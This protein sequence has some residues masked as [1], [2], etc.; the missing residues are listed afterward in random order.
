VNLARVAPM[1]LVLGVIG[2]APGVSAQW[3]N[4]VPSGTPLTPDGRPDLSAPA[5]RTAEGTPDLTGVWTHELTPLDEMRRLFGPAIDEAS[6][7]ELPGM[8]IGTV[9]KYGI[10]VLAELPPGQVE[11]TAAGA[12]LMQQ[13]QAERDPANVC[14]YF[15]FGFPL[16]GLLS[17]PI[18]IVQAPRETLVLYETGDMHRQIFTDGRTL[19]S[20][21][22][23]PAYLGYSTGRWEGDV[24]V[25]ET[26]GFNG[27]T[28]FDMMGHPR[29]E[30]L[31]VTERFHRRDFGHLDIEMT[32][33]DPEF[34]T[35][36][37]TV[38]IPH[39]LIADQDI[40][41]FFCENELDREHIL[42]ALPGQ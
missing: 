38:T 1:A 27:R 9:H 37:F 42:N 8:E 7:S 11:L 12:A 18:K 3:L 14:R 19:P 2:L 24:F 5:P 33:D 36:P 10:N 15:E 40:F 21:V 16:A 41:E 35:K 22:N 23:L 26:A 28:R 25:V 32:F 13:R 17:E 4:H 34:Y 29:S 6:K 31:R 20:E 39:M 30:A